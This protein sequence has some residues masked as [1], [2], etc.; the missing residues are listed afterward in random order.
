MLLA[1]MGAAVSRTGAAV[2]R[3]L[4]DVRFAV[5]LIILLALA[6]LVAT[7]VRQFPVTAADDPTGYAAELAA[8]HEAWDPS[9]RWACR[10]APCSWAPSTCSACST[11]SRRPGS[12]CSW[13]S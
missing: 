12:C 13:R 8:V 1:R 11:S 3:V 2:W 6:G 4:T 10:W 5:L 7:L 9:R